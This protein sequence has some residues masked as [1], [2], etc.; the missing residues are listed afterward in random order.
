M[1]DRII[2]ESICTSETIDHLLWF[3]EVFWYR[4]TVNCD[5]YGRFDARPQILKS[6]L[7]PLKQDIT[8]K[9]IETALTKLSALGLVTT[10][11]CSGKPYLQLVTWD[12]Y[13]RIRAK[14]SKF[15]APDDTCC[16]LTADVVNSRRNPI[17]S[18]PNPIQYEQAYQ[19]DSVGHVNEISN[20]DLE[21]FFESI[22]KLY[23]RKEGKGS[24][25][26]TQKT[27]LYHIGLDELN[28][29]IER[30]KAKLKSDGT[31]FKFIKQGSTFFNSGYIDYLDANYEA[32]AP[33]EPPK[34]KPPKGHIEKILN[35]DGDE[36]EVWVRDG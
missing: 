3:E 27:K 20:G 2:R 31:E 36:R 28:R 25:S 24:V 33:A 6:R 19:P 18:N 29:A 34:P 15:P 11:T 4:L 1:P 26:K 10:Y 23:P 8:E 9:V 30:Y 5:D 32:Q 17:Q 12:K 21:I 16:Q 14:R 22:W 7:F 13:Q 35:E